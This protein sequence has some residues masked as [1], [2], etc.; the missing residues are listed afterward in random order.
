MFDLGTSLLASVVRDPRALAIID[1]DKRLTYREWYDKISALVVAF[2]QLG[3]KPG[4]HILT[5]LQNRWEAAT[6]H[7]AC[8]FAGLVITP[9]N[10]RAKADEIDF[11]LSD[12]QARTIV[13]QDI[14][15]EAVE[16]STIA[17]GLC[18]IA[19]GVSRDDK[20][21]SFAQMIDGQADDAAPCVSADAWSIMLYTSGTAS[22]P[23]GVPRRHCAER[24]AGVAHVAQNMYGR[25]ERTLG[26][27]PLYHTMGVRSLIAMSLIGGTFVCLPRY[28]A[29]QALSAIARERITNLYLV[30]TLYHDLVHHPQLEQADVSSVRKLGFA[31]APM[32]DGLL[33]KLDEA[34]KPELFVNHYGSSEIYTFTVDQKAAAKPGSAGRAGINQLIR[35]V[36][37]GSRSA[38]EI[39]ASGEEGEIIALLGSEEAFEGYWQRPDADAKSLHDGWYFTGDTGFVDDDGD[40]FVTGRVDDMIIT[41]GENVSPV[42]IESCLSLHPAIS[43]VAVVGLPDAR[44]GK[45][46]TAFVKRTSAVEAPELDQFCRTSGLANFKRPR[47]FVFVDAI[48]KSPVGKL[49][50]R[51]LVSGEYDAE[52]QPPSNHS[53]N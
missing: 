47:R 12:S 49:L 48:P 40:L 16:A 29:A 14:S 11:Y 28:D 46:V 3:L 23:K 6:L 20:A 34:F 53:Q 39:A 13:Y 15:A 9:V 27:M 10:W 50:R 33:R 17:R 31:G 42:E 25:G 37:L 51:L 43:E 5:S 8:Q 32:T 2:G 22:R 35:V 7:W 19:V 30:P 44:W 1:G 24:A 52:Q 18:R 21:V 38:I 45:V 36:K 41:G 4:D 26:V